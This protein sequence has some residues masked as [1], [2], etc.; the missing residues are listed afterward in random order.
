M[1]Y[2]GIRVVIFL[3]LLSGVAGV[4]AATPIVEKQVVNAAENLTQNVMLPVLKT[5]KQSSTRLQKSIKG[6]CLQPDLAELQTVQERWRTLMFAWNQAVIYPAGS[7]RPGQITPIHWEIDTHLIRSGKKTDRIRKVIKRAVQGTVV[8]DQALIQRQQL[9]TRGVHALELLLFET[10][11]QENAA[12]ALI[13]DYTGDYGQRKCAYLQAVALELHAA[14]SY[15][16]DAWHTQDKQ[17]SRWPYVHLS[18]E[19]VQARTQQGYVQSLVN[20]LVKALL[21]IQLQKL[22]SLFGKDANKVYPQRA[23]SVYSANSLANIA[24]NLSAIDDAFHARFHGRD[25]YGFDDVLMEN[26]LS[27]VLVSFQTKIRAC[28]SAL[29]AIDGSLHEAVVSQPDAVKALA[30]AVTELIRLFQLQII[31]S[32]GV[33]PAFN[34]TDGDF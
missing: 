5:L 31:S 32:L 20:G 7:S 19:S 21:A 11:A 24:A 26:D 13:A 9:F 2:S 23:E 29:A 12:P 6:F 28:Q 22:E 10:L 27:Q 33:V 8:I 3:T 16:S 34:D 15:L 1:L 14:V 18:H 4:R 17:E 30:A 25:Y